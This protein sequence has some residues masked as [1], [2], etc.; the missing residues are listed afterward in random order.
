MHMEKRTFF[1]SLCV[2]IV[3]LA[4]TLVIARRGEPV[5]IRTNLE[6]LPMSIDGYQGMEDRFSESVYKE[7]N[8]DRHVYRHYVNETGERIDLYI[9]YYGTAKGGRTPHNPY[10]CLPGAGWGIA[11]D[12]EITLQAKG[13]PSSVTVNHIVA[14]KG[15]S[16]ET[17]L[18]WYQSDGDK[19]LSSGFQQNIERFVGRVFRNRN[20]G[21]F[22]RISA[23]A[24]EKD[25]QEV[26][27][28]IENF[29]AAVLAL[30]PHYWPEER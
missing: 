21:A 23:D 27:G 2:L 1:T 11:S 7:L 26:T 13:Y 29:A 25:L 20:D 8:A 14:Q 6:N 18:H 4:V 17:I 28:R 10:G 16:Y 9:G 30:L 15:M 12:E 22:V 5:V 3:T 24:E 19:V